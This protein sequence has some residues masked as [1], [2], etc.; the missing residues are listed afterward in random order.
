MKN[1]IIF[2]IILVGCLLQ[3]SMYSLQKNRPLFS[4][5]SSSFDSKIK[6]A[7]IV[8]RTRYHKDN[9]SNLL[10]FYKKQPDFAGKYIVAG[11]GCGTSCQA[12]VIINC[13]TGELIDAPTSTYGLIYKKNSHLLIVNNSMVK[14][15][16]KNPK[17][18]ILD[19][20]KD[21]YSFNGRSLQL[22]FKEKYIAT[23]GSEK[24]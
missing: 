13:K 11:W 21:Y 5:H 15:Y 16:N 8:Y 18:T 17:K 7:A 14:S 24:Q 23:A 6:K 10:H 9:K 2:L 3:C 20:S 22:L 4:E 19:V 12:N 1:K